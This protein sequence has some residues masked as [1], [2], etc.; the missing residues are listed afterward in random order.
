MEGSFNFPV[1]SYF[2]HN[3]NKTDCIWVSDV[4]YKLKDKSD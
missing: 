4:K 3:A 1:K 2:A